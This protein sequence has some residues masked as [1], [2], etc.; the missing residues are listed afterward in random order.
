MR[1]RSEKL[2]NSESVYFEPTH[3]WG[4]FAAYKTDAIE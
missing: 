2:P 1:V 4:V 3:C